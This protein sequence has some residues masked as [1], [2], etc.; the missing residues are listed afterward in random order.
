MGTGGSLGTSVAV[1]FQ[2]QFRSQH[3]KF[4]V[5]ISSTE[6]GN[7]WGRRREHHLGAHWDHIG[8]GIGAGAPWEDLGVEL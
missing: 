5:P 4:D 6:F 7:I 1:A 2:G 8:T 3:I